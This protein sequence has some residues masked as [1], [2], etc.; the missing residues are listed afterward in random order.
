M[1]GGRFLVNPQ[2]KSVG[3]ESIFRYA[4][5]GSHGKTTEGESFT[6]WYRHS[7]F[8]EVYATAPIPRS[9]IPKVNVTFGWPEINGQPAAVAS[10]IAHYP[11]QATQAG[12]DAATIIAD[13]PTARV[14]VGPIFER[15]EEQRTHPLELTPPDTADADS[16]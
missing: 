14:E 13:G 12:P 8:V 16:Q 9:G 10:A 2:A 6:Y 15:P 5:L 11:N 1:Q 3:M 4:R 7:A